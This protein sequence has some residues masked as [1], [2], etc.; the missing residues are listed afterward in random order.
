M[1]Q[2]LGTRGRGPCP[3]ALWVRHGKG[4]EHDGR[5][6]VGLS[7][8]RLYAH[9]PVRC[10]VRWQTSDVHVRWCPRCRERDVDLDCAY[11][12]YDL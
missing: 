8:C 6:R 2:G 3:C 10:P 1:A 9:R 4:R 5:E 11:A 12:K 7:V